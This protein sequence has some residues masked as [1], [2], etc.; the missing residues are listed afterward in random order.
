MPA[1]AQDGKSNGRPGN[2]PVCQVT[3]SYSAVPDETA[4]DD[5]LGML[6]NA[7]YAR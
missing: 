5:V 2:R 3:V 7:N 1:D 6:W 4:V